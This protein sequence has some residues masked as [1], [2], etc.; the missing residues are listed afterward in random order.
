MT[1]MERNILIELCE[2]DLEELA[3]NLEKENTQAHQG[4]RH[5]IFGDD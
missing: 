5:D 1:K 4:G 2:E 3:R